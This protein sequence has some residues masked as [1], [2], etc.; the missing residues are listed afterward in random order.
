MSFR[1]NGSTQLSL[2]DTFGSMTARAK[3]FMEKSW[4]KVFADEI[5][6]YIDEKPFS[7]LYSEKDSRPNTPVNVIIGGLILKELLGLSDDELLENLILDSR[8]QYALHTTSFREQPMSDRTLQRFRRRCCEYEAKTDTDLIHE[9]V[10]SLSSRIAKMMGISDSVKRMDS[11]MIEANIRRLSRTEL[12]YQCVSGLVRCMNKAGQ[13]VPGEMQHYLEPSD[14][15]RTF[16]HN[17]GEGVDSALGSI[18]KDGEALLAREDLK[19]IEE[20]KLLERCFSEQ[21]VTENGAARLRTPEDG[22]M[23]STIMQNPSD[24]DATYLA[25]ILISERTRQDAIT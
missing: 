24:P 13:E 11:M 6:P 7:V 23:D 5:F 21:T 16:Y 3:R 2:A 19:E 17:K 22:G 8:Y 18:L 14:Y 15:N 20:Y 4:A 9:C 12:L 10:T 1:L 25:L